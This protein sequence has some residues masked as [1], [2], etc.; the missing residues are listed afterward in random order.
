MTGIE[1]LANEFSREGLYDLV[2]NEPKAVLAKRLGISD[3]GLGKICRKADIPVPPRGYW[4][5]K[6]AGKPVV[7]IPL[8]A[9]G[10]GQTNTITVGRPAS[11]YYNEPIGELPP[12]PV[13]P[14]P[15]E[16]VIGKA[17]LQVGKVSVPKNLSS[18]H[19]LI[20]RLLAQDEDRRKKLAESPYSWNE[21]RFDT[22]AAKRRLRLINAI[23]L[24]LTR[25]GYNP[26]HHGKDAEDLSAH[27]GDQSVRF[28][29]EPTKATRRNDV[30][31][32]TTNS[33]PHQ[34][35]RI[36]VDTSVPAPIGI[37]KEWVDTEDKPL[38][39]V[40][41]EIVLG[42]VVY[43][44]LL[45]RA[46]VE[47]RY[48]FLVE[49][50]AE[51]EEQAR[52]AR[53]LAEQKAREAQLRQ[54]TARRDHLFCQAMS[55]EMAARLREFVATVRTH[56]EASEQSAEVNEWA[57]WALSEANALDPMHSSVQTIVAITGAAVD[58]KASDVC[59]GAPTAVSQS[60]SL[61]QIADER[62]YFPGVPWFLRARR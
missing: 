56:P 42:L 9:R 26:A 60:K 29:I 41:P 2:W 34:T 25:A 1:K 31:F 4:A 44:E 37:E 27:V 43:G 30:I 46:N 39:S 36:K 5:L 19:H 32:D 33:G 12:A 35:L 21:P 3:V 53:E 13:F 59:Q 50:K 45:H 17:R 16:Q 10:I 62:P 8:P 15:I 57:T 40:V 11:W 28:V 49:R 55:W 22:P 24:A 14:E 51:Q 47:H 61:S 6:D 48:K 7:Q 54:E 23:F 38:E 58:E 18:P 52:K 20:A